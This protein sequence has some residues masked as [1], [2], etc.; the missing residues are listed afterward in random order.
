MGANSKLT[1]AIHALVWAA[2]NERQG[3]TYSTSEEI[4]NSIKTNPVVVRRMMSDLTKAG[5]IES[6]R[7][8]GWRLNKPADT[9]TLWDINL[10][11]GPEET[12]ALHR[13]EPSATCPVARGI[14]PALKP[15][16]A[17]VDEAVRQELAR[18]TLADVFDETL[19]PTQN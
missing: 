3:S 7:G 16:Y 15:T 4:A 6:R 5:L 11:L 13:H 8:A 1:I 12:F 14:R 17:R 9:M 19:T 2:L 10:A 18:T